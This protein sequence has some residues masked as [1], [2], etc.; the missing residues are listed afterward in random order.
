MSST[1]VF[2]SSVILVLTLSLAFTVASLYRIAKN[3]LFR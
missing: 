1:E 2:L 3:V